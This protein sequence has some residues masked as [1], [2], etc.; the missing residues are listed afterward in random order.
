MLQLNNGGWRKKDEIAAAFLD[1]GF[2]KYNKT[3]YVLDPNG[4]RIL[5]DNRYVQVKI[6]LDYGIEGRTFGDVLCTARR[7][8]AIIYMYFLTKSENDRK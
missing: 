2:Q 5:K 1:E 8:Y 6:A 4:N 7:P 3:A